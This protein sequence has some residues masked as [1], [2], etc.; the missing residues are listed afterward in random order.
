MGELCSSPAWLSELAP[1]TPDTDIR[2]EMD[3]ESEP[4]F[5]FVLSDLRS[6]PANDETCD[7]DTDKSVYRGRA[8][9][10]AA[11]FFF[12]LV[13][14]IL[15]FGS[16]AFWASRQEPLDAF[17]LA[18]G[19]PYLAVSLVGVAQ[20]GDSD[21]EQPESDGATLENS[22]AEDVP[23]EPDEPPISPV[24]EVES[25]ALPQPLDME[26]PDPEAKPELKPKSSIRPKATPPTA[27]TSASKKDARS[28][29]GRPLGSSQGNSAIGGGGAGGTSASG[30]VG[31]Q[32]VRVPQPPYPPTSKQ[33]GEQ[34]RVVVAV[35]VSPAGRVTS[36]S[37][38]Q[39]SGYSRLDQAALNAA[40]NISFRAK[41]G[42][43]PRSSVTIQVPYRFK[44]KH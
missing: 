6:P 35:V 8:L 30:A 14:H 38:V 27:K 20:F 32:A 4:D 12:S 25:L 31:W 7:S 34:G 42:G 16:L 19:S 23:P 13:G 39:S 28:K 15:I 22:S 43:A 21:L 24:L 41:S 29:P 44:L 40:R 2:L 18:P 37:I 10:P 5:S 9:R 26:P 33:N 36:A 1:D 3:L 17:E 11:C